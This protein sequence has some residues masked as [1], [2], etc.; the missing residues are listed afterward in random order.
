MVSVTLVLTRS[1]IERNRQ[2]VDREISG[3]T[4]DPKKA[5]EAKQVG[6]W[7]EAEGIGQGAVNFRLR[8]WLLSR[9]RYWG[10]PIP[11]IH[12]EK[13]GEVPVKS[14]RDAY[15]DFVK[16]KVNPAKIG[17]ALKKPV[18]IDSMFGSG[19]VTTRDSTAPS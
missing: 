3:A 1:R 5:A 16:S 2:R 19:S 10:A 4:N 6:G 11:I 18:V 7:M 8:D 13:D 9:Q 14:F 12:C 17:A 15:L